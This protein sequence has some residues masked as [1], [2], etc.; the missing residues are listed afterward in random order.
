MAQLPA[1]QDQY[2]K[3]A[4]KDSKGRNIA[5]E[6]DE[7]RGSIP[8]VK[9]IYCHPIT[10]S[11]NTAGSVHRLTC[12]IFNNSVTPFTL[13]TLKNFLDALM[14]ATNGDGAIML[15]GGYKTNTETIIAS[16]LK[17][18][19]GSY[20]LVGVNTS[21][22]AAAVASSNFNDVFPGDSENFF[23]GVNKIN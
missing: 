3:Y 10:L 22:E 18:F 9:P 21:G 17:K 7:V 16:Y 23:D 15:S 2:V 19:E 11:N 6:V 12:L 20:Y 1:K 4:E 8:E 5:D 13:E 14:T